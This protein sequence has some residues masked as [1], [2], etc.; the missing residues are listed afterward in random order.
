MFPTSGDPSRG[1]M[2][3][4]IAGEPRDAR[5]LGVEMP[6]PVWPGDVVY[7]FESIVHEGFV[8]LD[9]AR[10]PPRV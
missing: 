1:L 8:I 10:R 6:V 4:T 9:F 3:G 2:M 7:G 5:L